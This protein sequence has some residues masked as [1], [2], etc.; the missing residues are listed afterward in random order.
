MKTKLKL[1]ITIAIFFL[2]AVSCTKTKIAEKA[3]WRGEIEYENGVKVVK[4]PAEPLYGEIFLDLEEDLS[5]GREDDDNYLFYG[6]ISID[7]DDQGNIYVLEGGNCRLQKFDQAG[8][9]LQTIGKKGQGPG[10]FEGPSRLF[11]DKEK[12]IYISERRK[13]KIHMFNSQGE[14]LKSFLLSYTTTNFSITPDEN[15]FGVATISTDEESNRCIVKMDPKGKVVKNIAQFA[16]IKLVKRKGTGNTITT[17]RISHQYVPALYFSRAVNNKHFYAYSSEYSLFQVNLEGDLELI[18][19]KEE[20]LHPISQK[21]KNKIYER[22]SNLEERWSKGVVKEAVQFPSHRPYFNRIVTDDR[23][24]IYVKRVKSVI[25][26]SEE[27][28]FD[29]FS[30]EGHYIYKA[31]LPFTPSVIKNGYFY[32]YYSSEETGEVK[33]KRYRA[34]NWMQIAEGI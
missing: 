29:I 22:F 19:K 12:N 32:E 26:E 9:Y 17:F 16:A 21:E 2:F 7:V 27:V 5:V 13:R 31:N 34:K 18:I 30:K 24:R 25:D 23:G 28:E 14:F 11:L 1:V 6:G 3:E 20:P 33:I 8:Q 15:I 4:N 10:E